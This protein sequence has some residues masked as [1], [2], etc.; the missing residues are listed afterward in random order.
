[1]HVEQGAYSLGHAGAGTYAEGGSSYSAINIGSNSYIAQ[2]GGQYVNGG[3]YS[4]GHLEVNQAGGT[5]ATNSGNGQTMTG[6]G[7]AA[8]HITAHGNA[9]AM[10]GQSHSYQQGAGSGMLHQSASGTVSSFASTGMNP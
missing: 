3:T 7:I 10:A 5:V 2:Q 9:G 8:T 4:N 1:M 6:F